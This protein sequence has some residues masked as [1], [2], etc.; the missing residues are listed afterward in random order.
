[1]KGDGIP[2]TTASGPLLPRKDL[3]AGLLESGRSRWGDVGPLFQ[4]NTNPAQR[5]FIE[6]PPDQR[7]AVR[8]APRWVEFRQRMLRVRSPI[9]SR[10]GYLDKA[11]TN[12][13]RRMAGEVRDRQHLIP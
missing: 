6:Q 4:R 10:L 8:H 12:G 1:M 5:T 11:R 13:Q 7:Y 3:F 9:A 2:L